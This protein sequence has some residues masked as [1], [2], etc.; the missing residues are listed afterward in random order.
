M[1]SVFLS[2]LHLG[3]PDCQAEYLVDFLA[4]VE[5]ERLYLVGD[6]VDL[7]ALARR[8]Y[9]PAAHGAALAALF[10]HAARGTQVFYLPGN[11][12][13]PLR[14]LAGSA[15]AG[16]RVERELVHETADGR[17]FRVSHG[18]EFDEEGVGRRWLMRL[19]DSGH[20]M[21]CFLNRHLNR[22]R[23]RAGLPYYPLS[24]HAKSRIGRALAFIRR[25]EERAASR[26]AAEGLDGQICG[27]I[28]FAAI[29]P[30]RRGAVPQ[31]RR[32]G[33]ALQRARRAR[34]RLL[35]APAL[36]RAQ[37]GAGRGAGAGC[38]HPSRP[39]WPRSRCAP[40]AALAGELDEAA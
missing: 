27:H 32:L 4:R 39:R 38:P 21:L 28:H 16:I 20:R 34:G 5:C 18:D 6:I 11:H 12:D 17:R 22:L 3:S 19:G 29:R 31:L 7:E 15:I 2:D 14:R 35:P 23:R 26:A 9:W 13:R 25:F 40:P 8:S 10:D 33:G 37:G 24:V 36:D 1:R 30:C